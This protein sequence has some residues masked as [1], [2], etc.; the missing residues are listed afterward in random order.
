LIESLIFPV[1]VLIAV[2]TS[3]AVASLLV[4]DAPSGILP[5]IV[6][7]EV[8]TVEIVLFALA[9]AVAFALIAVSNFTSALFKDVASDI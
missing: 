7:T 1:A 9:T 2:E 5:L 6:S 3:E 4:V 8:L